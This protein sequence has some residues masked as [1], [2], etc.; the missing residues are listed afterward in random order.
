MRI[1]H[2]P[3][4]LS[5]IAREERSR[6]MNKKLAFARLHG[7][8]KDREAQQKKQTAQTLWASHNHLERGNPVKVFRELSF[9]EAT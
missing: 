3:T 7:L 2:L 8:L 4:G 6:H 1:T 5:A 9:K